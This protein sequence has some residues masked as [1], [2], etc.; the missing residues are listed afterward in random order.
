MPSF[1]VCELQL[2][3][4]L[5]LICDSHM[6]WRIGFVSLKPCV[7]FS[8]FESFSLLSNFIF[9]FNE[10]QRF[11]DFKTI[12]SFNIKIIEKPLN[13]S[14]RRLIFKLQQEVLKFNICVSWSPPKTD[15]GRFFLTW[16]IEVLRTSVFLNSNF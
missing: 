2:T 16:K 6:S 13:L 4:V 9:L 11:L 15:V 5:L 14:L 8:I 7:G 12:I 3:T 10:D 1:F